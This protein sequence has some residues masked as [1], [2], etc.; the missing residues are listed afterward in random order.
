ME[1]SEVISIPLPQIEINLLYVYIALKV[2]FSAWVSYSEIKDNKLWNRFTFVT[3]FVQYAAKLVFYNLLRHPEWA[4]AKVI[5]LIATSTIDALK[6]HRNKFYVCRV[7]PNCLHCNDSGQ[8][9]K[10]KE[11]LENNRR[12]F[13]LSEVGDKDQI[14]RDKSYF[15]PCPKCKKVSFECDEDVSSKYELYEKFVHNKSEKL[16]LYNNLSGYREPIRY[17]NFKDDQPY[18][19]LNNKAKVDWNIYNKPLN[20]IPSGNFVVKCPLCGSG[21]YFDA[22]SLLWKCTR[23]SS[24][25]GLVHFGD[26]PTCPDCGS[27]MNKRKARRGRFKD[28]YFWGCNNFPKCDSIVNVSGG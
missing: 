9:S 6:P 12:G 27:N 3:D 17:P 11:K 14:D 25:K 18:A 20:D 16:D 4:L 23:K 15:I 19:K 22:R 13:V 8:V 10:H 26:S 2:M 1:S 5:P 28:R 7:L 24:C 21:M